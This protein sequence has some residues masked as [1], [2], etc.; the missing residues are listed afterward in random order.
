[1][2]IEMKQPRSKATFLKRCENG[3]AEKAFVQ[4]LTYGIEKG[5]LGDTTRIIVGLE[6]V[7]AKDS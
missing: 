2:R 4:T 3:V 6:A 5:S 7:K 1:M